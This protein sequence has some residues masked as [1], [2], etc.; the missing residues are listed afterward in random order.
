MYLSRIRLRDEISSG[1]QLARVLHNHS[2][3]YHQ[4]LWDLFDHQQRDFLFRKDV[5]KNNDGAK[6]APAF[7]MLSQQQPSQSSPLFSVETKPF[8][9]ALEKDQILRFNLC[10][11]PVVSRN[12]KRFDVIEDETYRFYHNAL[13]EFGLSVEGKPKELKA[14]LKG[15]N[16]TELSTFL[17][18]QLKA[19]RYVFS[20]SELSVTQK[21]H[22]AMMESIALRLQRWLADN[23]SRQGVF[24]LCTRELEDEETGLE[25]TVTDFGW[26]NHQ[27]NLLHEKGSKAK[28]YSVE[29]QGRLR[30]MDPERF[31][32]MLSKGIGPS[33]SFGCGL[34]L[35]KPAL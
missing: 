28:Y 29:L 18:D 19:S 21:L 34:M 12:R 3:S 10:A 4:L 23:P 1:S 32:L 6:N 8:N 17:D 30:V 11:N 7:F 14:R 22:N 16:K 35:V 13:N 9:L 5:S 26:D 31:S 20:L 33:K 24:E 27:C 15:V 2:Y 25:A